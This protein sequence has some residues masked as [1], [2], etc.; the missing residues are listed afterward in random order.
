MSE[1]EVIFMT[2]DDLKRIEQ[3]LRAHPI[4]EPRLRHKRDRLAAD[5]A[6]KH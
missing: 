3:Q 5:A 1:T 2:K 6:V 4:V